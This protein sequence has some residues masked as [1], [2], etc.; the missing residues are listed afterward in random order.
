MYDSQNSLSDVSRATHISTPKK[1]LINKIFPK[2]KYHQ[3]KI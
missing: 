3:T 1:N 2:L